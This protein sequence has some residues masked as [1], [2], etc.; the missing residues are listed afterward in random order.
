MYSFVFISQNFLML[1]NPFADRFREGG[2][3]IMSLIL[4]SFLLSLFFLIKGFLTLKKDSL[5]SKKMLQL[6]TD[7]SLLGLVLGFFG[8]IIGLIEVFDSIDALGNVDANLLGG[9]IKVSLLTATF[10]LLTFVIS[11]IGILIL[12]SLQKNS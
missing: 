6:T 10:G 2:S 5:V 12:R 8:S 7:S 4:I 1:S 11:R 9:G 3:F